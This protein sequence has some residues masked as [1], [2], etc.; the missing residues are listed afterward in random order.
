M[1]H[2]ED[3]KKIKKLPG[4]AKRKTFLAKK[5]STKGIYVLKSVDYLEE[6]DKKRADE[7]VAQMSRL[8]SRFTVRLI[9]TFVQN[10]ELL[11]VMEYY[12]DGDLRNTIDELQKLPE[13]ERII[14]VW[15]IVGQMIR[16]LDYLHSMGLIH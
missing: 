13:K 8:D 9:D 3:F 6:L 4:S 12:P 1:L 10:D 16:A 15:E 14:R 5:L 11:M 2:I 7:E